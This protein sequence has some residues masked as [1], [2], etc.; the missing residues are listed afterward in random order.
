MGFLSL[1]KRAR[2]G[3]PSFVNPEGQTVKL[4]LGLYETE[5]SAFGS[6]AKDFVRTIIFPRVLLITFPAVPDREQKH[7]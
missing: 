1:R 3:F 2:T 6:M 5:F 4:I 7:F